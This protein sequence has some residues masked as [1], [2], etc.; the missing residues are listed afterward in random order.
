MYRYPRR[1]QILDGHSDHRRS[2][3]L[4]WF[5][6]R[7]WFCRIA[8]CLAAL[9]SAPSVLGAIDERTIGVV[10]NELDPSSVELGEF[11]MAMHG[12]PEEQAIRVSIRKRDSI[13]L[14]ELQQLLIQIDR[15]R[16]LGLSSYALVWERPFR[17]DCMS[18]TSAIALRGQRD[19]CATG[20]RPTV[21]NPWFFDPSGA[22]RATRAVH[23][24]MLVTGGDEA[25]TRALIQRGLRSKQGI[26]MGK[27]L[28]VLS[29]DPNRDIRRPRFRQVAKGSLPRLKSR[30]IVGFPS[31]AEQ[32]MFYLT[33]AVRVPHL[34]GIEFLPGAVA[35]HVTSNGGTLYDSPQMSSLEWIRAGATATYGTV[36]EPCNLPG[37]FPDPV[38]LMER[39]SAGDSVLQAYWTS[40]AMPGQGVFVGDP[41]A[42][43]FARD[44]DR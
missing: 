17:A 18:I 11:Y 7:Q 16:F 37:K 26:A 25:T 9:L 39:Y 12:I 20:C 19:A 13:P 21:A 8:A 6:L 14:D 1:V 38:R 29:G 24:A 44:A 4:R 41:L 3:A 35:D 27:A 42:R 31:K 30:L 32:I 40:V 28:L 43:P 15:Q 34:A 23:P 22:K 10:I 2:P 33:G 36:V 5:L